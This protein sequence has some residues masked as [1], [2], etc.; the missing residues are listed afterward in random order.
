MD[1]LKLEVIL[2]PL[3]QLDSNF[4]PVTLP[5]QLNFLFNPLYWL[6]YLN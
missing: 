3:F 6:S 4:L 1:V 5:I 2:L